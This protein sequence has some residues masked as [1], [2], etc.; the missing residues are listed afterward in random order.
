MARGTRAALQGRRGAGNPR[1][2]HLLCFQTTSGPTGIS[3]NSSLL[4]VKHTLNLHEFQLT[5]VNALRP[6]P[7]LLS[8]K[9]HH[10]KVEGHRAWRQT[11]WF[12]P[13]PDRRLWQGA[14]S[15]PGNSNRTRGD[16][17]TLC[18]GGSGWLSEQCLLQRAARHWHSCPG[19][20][21]PRPW[22]CSEPRGCGTEGW[23]V[24]TGGCW[25]VSEGFSSLNGS[26][27][28]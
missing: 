21:S 1:E 24:G 5:H 13:T 19:V 11:F 28:L 27:I 17:L 23:A 3:T 18:C 14:V 8:Q 20:G 22:R 6:N 25:E 10:Q 4:S 15:A 7:H 9:C 12:S 26:V 16:G 2:T